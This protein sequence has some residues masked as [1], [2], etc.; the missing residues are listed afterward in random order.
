MEYT[1][2]NLCGKDSTELVFEVEEQITGEHK[3]FRVVK[4][5]DCGL[6]Y[7]N[8]RPSK[9]EIILYYPPETYYAHQPPGKAKRLRRGL[10]KLVREGLPGY[11]MHTGV[12]RQILGR[13]LGMMLLSQID[14]VV[15]FKENGRIL[16]VG[17]GNGEMIGWMKEYG[18][19]LHGIEIGKKACE[20][21][22]KQGLKTF[23][24]Q[25][26]EAG[27]P[28][29]Y[30]DTITVNHVLEHVHDPLFLLRE[31]NRI[32]KQDGLLI[33]DVPNFGCFHSKLFGKTWHAIMCPVHLYH[34]TSDSLNKMCDAAG[35]Q[36][37]KWKY[38]LALPFYYTPSIKSYRSANP[39]LLPLCSVLFKA[40]AGMFI[41]FIFSKN[42]GPGFSINLIAYASK[43][44]Q[45]GG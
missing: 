3:I 23:C 26:H 11:S 5:K 30:F 29:E 44:A 2:C 18:W 20:Q 32:L 19:D 22:E 7:I 15:P 28:A 41:K 10:K 1:R 43:C 34:F 6:V 31:C 36:V 37:K 39:G 27:Y 40:S 33:V 17:C 38:K 4:C 13:C 16:D 9:D 42:R 24:G 8:P 45:R 21:A 35:F 14:I 12:F 25:L